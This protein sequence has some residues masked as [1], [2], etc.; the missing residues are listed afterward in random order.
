MKSLVILFVFSLSL[1]SCNKSSDP[2]ATTDPIVGTWYYVNPNSTST[3]E[4]GLIAYVYADGTYN[5]LTYKATSS[6]NNISAYVRKKIGKYTRSGDTFSVAYSYETCSPV[7]SETFTAAI[8]ATNS[9]QLTYVSADKTVLA[10]FNRS[11][12]TA[13]DPVNLTLVEDT[14]CNKF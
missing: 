2:A 6:G 1:I 14:A 11:T 5:S 3:N 9:N 10:T 13:G 4:L 8:S 7:T 12:G